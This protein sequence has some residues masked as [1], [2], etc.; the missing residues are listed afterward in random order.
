[1]STE[2]EEALE[3]G[4]AL[5]AASNHSVLVFLE[6]YLTHSL[7]NAGIPGILWTENVRARTSPQFPRKAGRVVA[8]SFV[9]C[10][11]GPGWLAFPGPGIIVAKAV[12]G[13][14]TGSSTDSEGDSELR[15]DLKAAAEAHFTNE[16]LILR[17]KVRKI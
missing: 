5:F 12:K 16:A 2:R 13:V 17:R 6:A 4:S 11:G 3:T 15:E 1:M 8:K 14:D 7:D 9:L 10:L